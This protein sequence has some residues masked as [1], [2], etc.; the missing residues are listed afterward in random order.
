MVCDPEGT[1]GDVTPQAERT[2][3][4]RP[5]AVR[6]NITYPALFAGV[7]PGPAETVVEHRERVA[8]LELEQ[9]NAILGGGSTQCFGADQNALERLGIMRGD[10]LVGERAVGEIAPVSVEFGVGR[11]RRAGERE[12]LSA[13]GRRPPGR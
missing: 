4:R 11:V 1:R 13:G 7:A 2:V 8:G 10:D 9:G 12:A 6:P 3:L 5:D